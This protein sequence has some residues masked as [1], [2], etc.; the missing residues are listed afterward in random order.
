MR[1]IHKTAT[2][3]GKHAKVFYCHEWCEYVVQFFNHG[4]RQKRADYHTDCHEDAIMTAR[5]MIHGN[6]VPA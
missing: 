1:L 6:A 2:V 4:K 3:D 5:F